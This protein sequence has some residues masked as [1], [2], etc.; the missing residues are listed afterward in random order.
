LVTYKFGGLEVWEVNVRWNYG[1]GFP[2]TQTQGFYDSLTF[3]S[4]IQTNITNENGQL[5][6]IYG[7]YNQGRL[8]AYHRLDFGITR[9]FNL[10]ETSVL[11]ANFTITNVYDRKNIFYVDRISNERIYQ[12]PVMPSI[13]M[14]WSF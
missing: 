2:F 13:G 10:S 7:S 9:K 8:S 14:N 3:P 11:D 6:V 4:G 5:G 12:L 1:S